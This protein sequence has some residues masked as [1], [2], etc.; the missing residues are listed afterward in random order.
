MSDIKVSICCLAYNHESYIRQCLDGFLMQKCNFNFEVLIHDDASKDKTADIIKEYEDKYSEIIKPIYQS[1]NQHSKGVKP[2]F[3]F[4]IPRAKG[5]YI[6]FCE[7][8]DYWT[9]PYKLQKQVDFLEA[10][11]E[12]VITG[13]DVNYVDE[14]NHILKESYLIDSCKKDASSEELKLDY[15]IPTLSMVFRAQPLLNEYPQEANLVK[16]GDTFLTAVIGQYGKYK[17][18]HDMM[19]AYRKHAGGIWSFKTSREQLKMRILTFHTLADYYQSKGDEVSKKQY[20]IAFN[21]SHNL[22]YEEISNQS[23]MSLNDFKELIYLHY[24]SHGILKTLPFLTL[25]SMRII[26]AIVMS[27]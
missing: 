7:G 15:L 24:K 12:Y 10:N 19:A 21:L 14:N 6:A 26:L 13:H 11:P 23:K 5:K 1:E 20:R 25:K 22:F 16:N 3:S 9:D 17:Y 4:N 8:D 2:T 27:R 18:M